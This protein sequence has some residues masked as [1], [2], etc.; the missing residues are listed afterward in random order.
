MALQSVAG[1]APF[2]PW[3][4]KAGEICQGVT[5]P[6]IAALYAAENSFRY[7]P[8]APTSP[9]GARGPGQF[10]PG[11]WAVYGKDADGNGVA[12][13]MSIA[14]SVMASGHLLCDLRKQVETWI[15]LGVVHGDPLDLTLA[16]YNAGSGA[17]LKSH[18]MPSGTPDYETQTKPYVARI[19]ASASQFAPLLDLPDN[20][21]GARIVE[22]ATNYLGLPYVWGGGNSDG[23]SMGGFDCSGLTSYALHAATA[24]IVTLPRTSENQWQIGTEIPLDQ[25]R[26]GD[27]LFGNWGTDGPG[28]VAIYIG[29]GQMIHAPNTG[30]VVRISPILTGM[31]ARRLV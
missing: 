16:G 8:A 13:I 11:T 19:R 12:D 30:D 7:G 28:H 18:G 23:P 2:I 5:A 20:G 25:A 29:N 31:R 9:S 10:M 22:Q 26:P 3:L 14:D 4:K 21:L 1:I 17:V 6:T 24:G 15:V 27:L